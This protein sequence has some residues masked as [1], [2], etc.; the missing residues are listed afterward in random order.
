MKSRAEEDTH[1]RVSRLGSDRFVALLNLALL[2]TGWHLPLQRFVPPH[3]LPSLV[4]QGR[5]TRRHVFFRPGGVA[6]AEVLIL[7]VRAK[8]E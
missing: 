3:L 7:A 6:A 4:F 5:V 1:C 2:W 8:P